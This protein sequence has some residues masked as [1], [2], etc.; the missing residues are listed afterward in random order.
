MLRFVAR[1]V[2]NT[3]ASHHNALFSSMDLVC[4][5]EPNEVENTDIPKAI[6]IHFK[7]QLA[8]LLSTTLLGNVGLHLDSMSHINDL[9]DVL[10]HLGNLTTSP[11]IF[12]R[13]MAV[14]FLWPVADP[15]MCIL[16]AYCIVISIL[17][18]AGHGSIG[19]RM[20]MYKSF[21]SNRL[22]VDGK[23]KLNC[24]TLLNNSFFVH[25]AKP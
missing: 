20:R 15:I 7:F 3:I 8:I 10:T 21:K 5:L 1:R 12:I 25:R 13:Q 24:E 19:G 9:G 18:N 14:P 22:I 6:R 23:S 4:Y 2:W 17:F 11:Y 16:Q